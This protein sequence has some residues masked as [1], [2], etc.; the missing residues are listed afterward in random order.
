M[1]IT[2]TATREDNG[3]TL[4]RSFSIN[5]AKRAGLW[6]TEQQVNGTDGWKYKSSPWW[7]HQKRMLYYRPLGYLARDLFGDVLNEMYITEEAVDIVKET[8]EIITTPNIL[9]S[10]PPFNFMMSFSKKDK[11]KSI[12]PRY[13]KKII[14]PATPQSLKLYILFPY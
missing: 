7:K 8:E 6:I 4:S 13:N 12:V 3:L 5:D 11:I 2:I 1:E 10:S 14:H 9:I